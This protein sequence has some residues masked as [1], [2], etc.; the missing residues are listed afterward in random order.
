MPRK[1]RTLRG[2]TAY[3]VLNRATARARIFHK[4]ADYAAFEHTL[5]QAHGRYPIRILSPT[6]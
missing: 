5:E 3:H 2:N 4:A 1:P 6:S